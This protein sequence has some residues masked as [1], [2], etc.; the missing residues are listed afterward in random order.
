MGDITLTTSLI[1]DEDKVQVALGCKHVY[2]VEVFLHYAL[3]TDG[4]AHEESILL[5]KNVI[6]KDRTEAIHIVVTER[7]AEVQEAIAESC[8]TSE[9]WRYTISYVCHKPDDH[10]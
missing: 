4:R 10:K 7:S 1:N 9:G 3:N 2:L 6:A 8:H 5:V